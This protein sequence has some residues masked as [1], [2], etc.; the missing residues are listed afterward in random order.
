MKFDPKCRHEE[1]GLN[2]IQGPHLSRQ[3]DQILSYE[4]GQERIEALRWPPLALTICKLQANKIGEASEQ[5]E[6]CAG[7]PAGQLCPCAPANILS[8]DPL[9]SEGSASLAQSS[10]DQDRWGPGATFLPRSSNW[11]P[12]VIL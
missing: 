9:P 8:P 2:I 6:G 1:T 11:I 12:K 10:G 7:S 3:I 5:I 4:C